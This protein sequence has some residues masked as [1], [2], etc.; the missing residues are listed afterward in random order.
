MN[1]SK[2]EIE[3]KFPP[4]F[5]KERKRVNFGSPYRTKPNTR[6]CSL[7]KSMDLLGMALW[8]LKTCANQYCLCPV[9]G[10][11]PSTVNV[12]LEYAL[13]V[14]FQVLTKNRGRP[15]LQIRWMTL[16]EMKASAYR[17]LMSRSDRFLLEGVFAVCDGG[18]F[19]CADFI[20]LD[21]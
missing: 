15:E 5:S 6:G 4:W 7:H 19:T 11:V 1:F 18:R 17:L 3:G 16:Q 2:R 20:D 9:F 14:L 21:L 10:F 12:W 13:E 8:Y